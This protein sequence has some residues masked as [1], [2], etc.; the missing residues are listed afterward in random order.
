MLRSILELD[1]VE[2]SDIMTHRRKVVLVDLNEPVNDC[3]DK[4]LSS[5]YTRIPVYRGNPD[6]ISGVLHAKAL[7]RE[8]HARGG[9]TEAI[10]L[11]ILAS[12]PWFIPDTTTLLDQ[13]QAF[14]ER[15]EHFAI[16]IDE[17]GDFLGIV[18]LEDILEQIVGNI[19]DETDVSVRGVRAQADG[20]YIVDGSVMLRTLSRDLEWD[21]P[22]GDA[23]TIAGLVLHE[24][25]LI[26]D[27]GQV[28]MFHGFRFEVLRRQRNQI[29]LIRV[30]PP[31]SL[32]D[33]EAD[34]N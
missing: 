24:A 25:R 7:L 19:D 28:F 15:R 33:N 4:V 13:L 12:D 3:V 26:P 11:A 30:T 21:L 5:P 29:T 14:R 22:D 32:I 16:V 6:D 18:T 17:Y 10:D 8:V 9:N 20:S 23:A 34:T 2:V 1:D 31:Q 27:P